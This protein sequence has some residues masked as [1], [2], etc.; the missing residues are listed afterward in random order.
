[1]MVAAG[2]Y[3]PVEGAGVLATAGK[4]LCGE[5]AIV[6]VGAGPPHVCGPSK[7]IRK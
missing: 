3:H 4:F 1:V 2:P 7:P 6:S 5:A